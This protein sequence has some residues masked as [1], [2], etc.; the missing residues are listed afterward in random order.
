MKLQKKLLV[1]LLALGLTTSCLGPDNMYNSVK[2]W[3][4]GLSEKDWVNEIVFLGLVII[5]VYPFALMGDILI[6][7]TVEYWSGDNLIKDPAEF[8]G[9]RRAAE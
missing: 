9:F 5:P 3:N 4:A 1:A 7:N 8:P 6:F 2:N